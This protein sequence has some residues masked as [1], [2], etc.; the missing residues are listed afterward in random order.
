MISTADRPDAAARVCSQARRRHFGEHHLGIRPRGFGVI[1][2]PHQPHAWAAWRRRSLSLSP[3]RGRG[4]LPAWV[5]R[6]VSSRSRRARSRSL[7]MAALCR[8]PVHIRHDEYGPSM[9]EA[10]APHVVRSSRARRTWIGR[11]PTRGR[12]RWPRERHQGELGVAMVLDDILRTPAV[13]L[14]SVITTGRCPTPYHPPDGTVTT[15]LPT[16]KTCVP[17]DL[18]GEGVGNAMR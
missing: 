6:S 17:F 15:L 10:C 18:A 12:R 7:W 2:A 3:L 13:S 11:V 8:P 14:C 4:S 1:A 5:A 9:H 16:C